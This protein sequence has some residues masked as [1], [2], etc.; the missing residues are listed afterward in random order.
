MASSS[1]N[2]TYWAMA[3]S[4]SMFL[5]DVVPLEERLVKPTRKR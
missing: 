5:N 4:V 3:R 1:A 2:E